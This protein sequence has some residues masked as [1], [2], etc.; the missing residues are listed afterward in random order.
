MLAP[1]KTLPALVMLN[2]AATKRFLE[3]FHARC[4]HKKSQWKN[5]AV[6]EPK[7]RPPTA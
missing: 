6:S 4:L 5:A 1:S 3:N 2:F 7:T